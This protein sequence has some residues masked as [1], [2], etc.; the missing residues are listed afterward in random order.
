MSQ[1]QREAA[2]IKKVTVTIQQDW[3]AVDPDNS[4]DVA[5]ATKLSEDIVWNLNPK[6]MNISQKRD[7]NPVRVAGS[8]KIVE[9]D[10]GPTT[11]TISGELLD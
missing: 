6:Q 7:V 4:E 11:A 2:R 10:V 9:M 1:D 3:E 8:E 5:L